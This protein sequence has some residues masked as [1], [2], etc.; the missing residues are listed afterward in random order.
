[1][2]YCEPS[3]I[4]RTQ[5]TQKRQRN[6]PMFQ[7]TY[8]CSQDHLDP[9]KSTLSLDDLAWPCDPNV[10]AQHVGLFCHLKKNIAFIRFQHGLWSQWFGRKNTKTLENIQKSLEIFSRHLF[11]AYC[12][13]KLKRSPYQKGPIDTYKKDMIYLNQK[14]YPYSS[15][16]PVM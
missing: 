16:L 2:T 10:S 8:G 11:W 4:G 1:M 3:E 15:E 5:V 12:F 9:V 14:D 13:A 6:D 7:H